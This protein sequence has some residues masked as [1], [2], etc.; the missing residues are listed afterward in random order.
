[1][2]DSSTST[3]LIE[4]VFTKAQ[5]SIKFPLQE[6]LVIGRVYEG[7]SQKPD[8]DLSVFNAQDHGV[9]RRHF[10]LSVEQDQ[11]FI[12]DLASGNGTSVNGRRLEA[13]VP[14]VI[15]HGD[16]LTIGSLEAQIRIIISPSFSRSVG[17]GQKSV[18]VED[19]SEKGNGQ[20]ILIVEDDELVA[21]MLATMLEVAG[22]KPNISRNVL[23]AMR[24]IQQQ[25]P[26]VVLLDLML[27]NLNGLELCRFIR[28]DAQ[29]KDT[30]IIMISAANSPENVE[31]AM[32]AGAD[33]FL[34]KPVSSKELR[35]VVGSL[36]TYRERHLA[37]INTKH[38][39][40][41]A[42]LT[43]LEPG[44]R[45]STAVLFVSGHSENPLIVNLRQPMTLGRKNSTA[46]QHIDLTRFDAIELGVSRVHA[47]LFFDDASSTFRLEDNS[48]I[49]G[50]YLNGEPLSA[51][52]PQ[53][54]DNADEIRLGQLRLY[55]YFLTDDELNKESQTETAVS[56]ESSKPEVPDEK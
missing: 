31:M 20:S 51:H 23:G 27:P 26:D 28:R 55:I 32:Q 16:L 3:W 5:R 45:R 25:A 7:D 53:V 50:T 43:A 48:S 1:M 10:A 11:L 22:Y 47:T 34:G 49:N 52:I 18:Q 41:T 33:I 40:G 14:R 44:S 13:N 54:L 46:R 39:I 30:P 42:P 24:I 35:H 6:S 21:K 17:A 4:L 19:Q 8:V 38:L 29:F 15:I 9:S 2:E 12:T 56:E 37:A 36:I